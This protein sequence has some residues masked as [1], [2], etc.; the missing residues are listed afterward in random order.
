MTLYSMPEGWLGM[1]LILLLGG[2]FLAIFPAAGYSS[3][4]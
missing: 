2:T 4:G 1:L 3:G